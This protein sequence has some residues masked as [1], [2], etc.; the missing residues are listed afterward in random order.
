MDGRLFHLTIREKKRREADTVVLYVHVCIRNRIK[1]R[2]SFNGSADF[3]RVSMPPGGLLPWDKHLHKFH[4]PY[5]SP[6]Q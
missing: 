4:I 3:R 2:Q 6:D 5:M 1:I